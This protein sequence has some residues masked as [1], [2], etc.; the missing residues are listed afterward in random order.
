MSACGQGRRR[1][2]ANLGPSARGTR[3]AAG[4]SVTWCTWIEQGARCR[5]PPRR[6][7]DL[8]GALLVARGTRLSVQA[9]GARRSRRIARALSG[10]APLADRRRQ[11]DPMP[12]YGL[13]RLWNAC[14]WNE[15]A[16]Q[17]FRG[18]LDDDCQRNLL[19]Y[20]FLEPAAR[21]LI[22][23]WKDRARRLLAEFR[24][25]FAR[26]FATPRSGYSSRRF[27]A[28]ALLCRSVGSAGRSN[29]RRGPSRVQS[30]RRRRREFHP[31]HI[32][33]GGAT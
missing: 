19:C 8:A 18:W 25:D 17:L 31:T 28:R 5:L 1:P 29:P 3:R 30:P 33:P 11:S 9:R 12:A 10:R 20:A 15:A 13:D 26:T 6:S 16:A 21:D 4:I 14:C 2:A 7:A 24:A 32:R 27:V 22:P 23:A